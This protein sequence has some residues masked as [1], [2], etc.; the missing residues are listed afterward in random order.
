MIYIYT[1]YDDI[2][3]TQSIEDPETFFNGYIIS[4]DFGDKEVDAMRVIDSAELLDK[5]MG[6]VKTP[7]GITSID[8]LST[9]CK[10]VTFIFI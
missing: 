5:V 3:K 6:S 1:S 8:K 7:R 9:G 10:T 2:D 4:R